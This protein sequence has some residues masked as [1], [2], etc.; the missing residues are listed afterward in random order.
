[1][2]RLA[3]VS[4][5]IPGGGVLSSDQVPVFRSSVVS[6]SL[7]LCPNRCIAQSAALCHF[8]KSRANTVPPPAEPREHLRALETVGEL[9]QRLR[10]AEGLILVGEMNRPASASSPHWRCASAQCEEQDP[11]KGQGAFF[12]ALSFRQPP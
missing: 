9:D 10:G 1:V 5:A 6:A 2:A 4:T 7:R 3:Q 11:V 8:R 12:R